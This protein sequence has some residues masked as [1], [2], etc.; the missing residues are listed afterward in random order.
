MNIFE[1]NNKNITHLLIIIKS[2][3]MKLR[4]IIKGIVYWMQFCKIR[5]FLILHGSH[6]NFGPTSR[7]ELSDGS[8]PEDIVVGD[9]VD[10]YGTISSQNHG[11]INIGSHTRLGRNAVIQC[12]DSVTIGSHVAIARETVI[13]DNN[14]H[15][16]S[17]LFRK[18]KSMM[19]PSSTVHLWRFSAH[20]PVVIGDNVWIGERSRICKGVTIGE[21]SIVAANAVVTKDVPANSIAAGNPA[22]IIREGIIAELADPTDCDDFNN[23]IEQ[24]GRDFE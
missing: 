15:P 7:V 3:I 11:K 21:N 5:K 1:S 22:R 17:V 20:K 6:Y 16:S 4:S 23:Y 13:S 10:V 24:Y 8:I 19:P 9:F 14:T 2:N 12:C 18:V